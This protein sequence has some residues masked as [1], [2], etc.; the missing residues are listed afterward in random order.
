MHFKIKLD[1]FH[2]GI[3]YYVGEDEIKNIVKILKKKK[4]DTTIK[5]EDFK[6]A[7][8]LTSSDYIWIREKDNY[9]TVVHENYHVVQNLKKYYGFD[10]EETEAYISGYLFEQYIKKISKNWVEIHKD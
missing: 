6:H 4:I 5:E 7:G 8:G 2:G 1:I 3:D 10:D 9:D